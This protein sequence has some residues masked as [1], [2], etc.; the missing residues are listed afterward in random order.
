MK[1]RPG[2]P[3]GIT[4]MDRLGRYKDERHGTRRF[5]TWRPA[6]SERVLTQHSKT[7]SGRRGVRG[8]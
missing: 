7:R 8:H 4:R 1:I 6:D 3:K 5:T 2:R